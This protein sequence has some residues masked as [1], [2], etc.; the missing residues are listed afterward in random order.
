MIHKYLQLKSIFLTGF[1]FIFTLINQN[2]IAEK[3]RL[4]T[5][6]DGL[7]NSHINQIYQDSRGNIWIATENG[8]NKFNGYDF[9]VYL[10]I[11]NDTNSIQAN[12]VS[13]V[14][15]DSRGLFWIATSKGLL[16][17]DRTRNVF[18]PWK[19]GYIHE[20]FKG[21]RA[22][23]IMEDSNNNLWISYPGDG[24]VR[25]D[26]KTL[27]PVVFNQ[28]NSGIGNNLISC[29]FED[30]Y[31]NI[32]F[33]TESHG[34]YVFNPQ[35]YLTQHYYHIT[36]NPTSL[37]DNNVYAICA[38]AEGTVW[39]G[40]MG[41]GINIYDEKT[42]SFRHLK[43][44]KTLENQIFSLLID[45]NQK[46]WAGTDGAGIFL[47]DT[48]GNKSQYKEET[49]YNHDL[50]STKVHTLFQDKQGNIW[51]ALFQ[52]GVLFISASGKYFQ[53]IGFNPFNDS[54]SIG[55]H[56]V[57]SIIEDYNETI[58]VGTDGEGLYRIFNS[59]KIEHLTSEKIPALKGDIV[60]ALFE[61]R[62]KNVWVGTYVNG[63]CRYNSKIEKCDFYFRKTIPIT[64]FNDNHINSFTQDIDGKI[65]I[66]TN[67]IGVSVFD[68]KTQKFKDYMYY[69][70]ESRNRIS[71]NCVYNILIDRDNDIW[72]ATSNGLN[73]L[74]KKSD[75]FEL[76]PLADGIKK[77]SN[78]MYILREDS[79]GNI[80][81]GSS[82]GL[83]YVDKKSGKTSLIT[84]IDGLP[85]N[86]IT[87]IEEDLNNIMWISTGNG[88]CRYD[89]ETGEF[90]NFYAEDGIQSNEFRRGSSF[91]GKSGK[92][93]FGGIKGITS[94]QPSGFINEN[95][96]MGLVFTNFILN[97]QP[98]MVGQSDILKKPL[99]ET[100]CIYLK[101]N[102]NSFTFMFAALEFSMP[103]RVKYH[104]KMEN[105]D[106]DWRLISAK[107]RSATYTNLNP[108]NY[109]FKVQATIDGKNILQKDM[110]VIIKSP[111][112]L[113]TIAKI[114]YVL[115]FC[116]TI[117]GIYAYMS[118]RL[119]QRNEL[120]EKEQQK[121]LSESKLNIFTDLSHEIKTPLTLIISP[122][123]RL[124][125]LS[126]DETIQISLKIMYQNANRI[127]RMVNQLM[128]L[129]ALDSGKLKLKVV[130]TDISAFIRN[131]M[132]SFTEL[133]N[134]RQIDFKLD[135][136]D[137]LPN[138]YADRDCLDKIIFNL[139]SNA[140][141][142]T[143]HA[144]CIQINVQT[145]ENE[146][147]AIAIIDTGIGMTNEQMDHIFERF[148]LVRDGKRSTK[149]GTGIGLHLA[150][151][152]AEL[153]YGSLDVESELN[154]GTTF[155]L[156]IP[157]NNTLYKEDEIG[158]HSEEIPVNAWHS[159]I[160]NVP[161]KLNYNSKNENP[162]VVRKKGNESILIVEDDKDTAD[163]LES[164]LSNFYN[165]YK[166]VNGKEGLAKALQYMP[167]VMILDVMIP[168]IDGLTLCKLI[169][170]N[171]KT[172]HIPVILL[173]AKSNIE[174]RIEGLETGADSYITKPF[175]INHLHTRIRQLIQLREV[176]KQKYSG[177][178]DVS[179][180]DMKV[181]TADEK[182]LNRLNAKLKEHIT[183]PDLSVDFLSKE[184]GISRVH[185]NRRLK[186]I[187]N[188]SPGDYIRNYRLKNAAWLLLNKNMTIAEIAYAVGFSSQ[189]YFSNAFKV[190][191][192]ITPTEYSETHEKKMIN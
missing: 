95:P 140:F 187:T 143:P 139:L 69:S 104:V 97:N 15:E 48:Q 87:G 59:G 26:A 123:E 99:D 49:Y 32:W 152:M 39:V 188:E 8:L 102:Q 157:N 132:D 147:I 37:S 103:Q 71:G 142:F 23:Y 19:L 125:K 76:Y 63:F 80:Y 77:F 68:P 108:G 151:K 24:I 109:I 161:Y 176:L 113:T 191:Y 93:Y 7:S 41:G 43:S 40:T 1:L 144:G 159:S 65:W 118:F 172:C 14:C 57:L 130:Q 12:Y 66:G 148:Y 83:H 146:R 64:G 50:K 98:V 16:Q 141:K 189:A 162:D 111:W 126:S 186:T 174:Y 112:W 119:K 25:L 31:G 84:T 105:F 131:L 96:L 62:E 81:V 6:D 70:E 183:N 134:A 165:I 173:T 54:K 3:V 53:N 5:P 179:E 22:T 91:K 72:A 190:H 114:I 86:M 129:R 127:L 85:D 175:F 35:S 121:E 169:K 42:Q 106:I 136:E 58:W 60:T 52:K 67:N 182:L 44:D 20:E 90:L 13:F 30:T 47:Y 168:E 11:P 156:R 138:V 167:D 4:F 145:E 163:Y 55:T 155:T 166:A 89:P 36:F 34:V 171:E 17:Y 122:L 116:L 135:T 75:K 160:S 181:V 82:H 184:L 78:M 38:D 74:N 46:V 158:E 137:N 61:D 27:L 178:L 100:T 107:N 185:L 33:G 192:G 154:K 21:R 56:C 10:T 120:I 101:N 128:D 150:Q 177:E 124:M 73:L 79:K 94:F 133:A 164:E 170:K 117:Y 29:M 153:H 9:E 110:Q 18:F 2:L 92:I 51:A 45:K 149:M 115:S 28:S 180:N 88:L